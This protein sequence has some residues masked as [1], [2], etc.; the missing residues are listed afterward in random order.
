M[1]NKRAE[2]EELVRTLL[3]ILFFVALSFG[4]YYL[5]KRLTTI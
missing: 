3:W 2:I 1:G 4:V 5:I